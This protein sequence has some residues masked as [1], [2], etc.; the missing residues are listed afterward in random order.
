MKLILLTGTWAG[1]PTEMKRF[2]MEQ[3]DFPGL[4]KNKKSCHNRVFRQIFI[5]ISIS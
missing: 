2:Q 5:K 4:K 3:L 1:S